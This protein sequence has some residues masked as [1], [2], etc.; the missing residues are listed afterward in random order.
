MQSL[1]TQPP[2]W[3]RRGFWFFVAGGTGFLL[4]LAIS[5]FLH[6]LLGLGPV[7]SAVTAAL[8]SMVP[9]FWMQRR[10]TFRSDRSK[11]AA[12]PMYAL[13][14]LGNTALIGVL[15]SI[16]ARMDMPSAVV[17]FIAGLIGSLVSYV[18]QARIVFR[19][20]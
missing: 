15:T 16:G 6:Y 2:E 12:L 10:L 1:L 14:Q 13:L 19:S 17:F 11:R 8:L 9:T 3:L 5:N 18:V 20:P 7:P 4:Y